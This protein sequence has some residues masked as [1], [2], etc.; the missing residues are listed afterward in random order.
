MSAANPNE[1]SSPSSIVPEDE[2]LILQTLKSPEELEE[3]D[4]AAKSAVTL[5]HSAF[6]HSTSS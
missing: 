5:L 2:E 4:R 1:V 6:N 3:E